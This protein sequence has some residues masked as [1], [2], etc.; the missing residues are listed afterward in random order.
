M[1]EL[2]LWCEYYIEDAVQVS[3]LLCGRYCM[4]ELR[5]WCE[6]YVEGAVQVS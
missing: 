4:G 1:G 3:Q 5:L 6:Y 2:R